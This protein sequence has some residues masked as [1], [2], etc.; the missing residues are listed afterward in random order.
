M[1][2]RSNTNDVFR[3]SDYV[4]TARFYECTNTFSVEELYQAFKQRFLE[5]MAQEAEEADCD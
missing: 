3:H 1:I 4:I 2:G 5:E